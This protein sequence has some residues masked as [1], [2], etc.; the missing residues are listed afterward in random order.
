MSYET[1]IPKKHGWIIS[2]NGND[3]LTFSLISTIL[4]KLK[5]TEYLFMSVSFS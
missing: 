1:P 5:I 2:L 3:L 4:I